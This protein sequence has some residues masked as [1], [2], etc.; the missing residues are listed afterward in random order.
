M[1]GRRQWLGCALSGLAAPR[2]WARPRL[3]VLLIVADDMNCALGCYGNTTVRSPH[4]DRLAAAGVLFESAHCQHPLCAPSRASV[5]S[6]SVPTRQNLTDW[7]MLPELFRRQGYYTAEVGKIFHTGPEHEDP[8]SWDYRLPEWGK[9]PRKEEVLREHS[10]PGPR[11]HT[12]AWQVLRT[13]DEKTPDGILA[14]RAV[15]LI[16][17]CHRRSQPFFIGVGF[18]RPHAPYAAPQRYFALYDPKRIPLPSA[19]TDPNLPAAAWY[20]LENQ[21]RLTEAEQRHYMAAYFACISFVDAQIGLLLDGL[22]ELGLEDRTVVVFLSDNGYHIGEH[23]MWHKMTLFEE[24]TRVPFIVRAPGAQGNGRRARGLV[25]LVDLYA[26]LAELCGVEAPSRQE[27][28]SLVPLLNDPARPGKQAVYTIVGRHEDKRLSHQRPAWYGRSVRTARW[29][30]TEWDEGRRGRE[31]YDRR[32]DP[33]ESRNLAQEPRH[34]ATVRE[35]RQLLQAVPFRP[36]SAGA[37]GI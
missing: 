36:R 29:R 6:L 8:R 37:T 33:G 26:T 16:H 2:L 21:P 34:A 30:Y 35:M 19:A 7:V 27:G 12:M 25:E 13:P 28:V 14:R 11:N 31:L 4:L 23:G 10:A 18:R 1:I 15:E 3:N 9:T 17:E 22:E 24:S 20:E 5:L 32:E